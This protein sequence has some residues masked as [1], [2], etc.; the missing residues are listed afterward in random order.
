MA[1]PLERLKSQLLTSGVQQDNFALYQVINQLIGFLQDEVII[2]SNAISGGGGGGGIGLVNATYLT[3]NKEAGLPNSLQEIA[4]SGIQ[5]NDASGRRIISA[6]IPFGLD[7]GEDGQDGV[8][9]PPGRIGIVGSQGLIGPPGMPGEDGEDGPIGPPGID[10]KIGVNGARGIDGLTGFPGIDGEDGN[11]GDPGITGPQGFTGQQGAIGAPGIP[12]IDGFEGEQGDMGIPGPRGIQ[13]LTG[14]NSGV[15]F[16]FDPTDASDIAGYKKALLNPSTNAES[17]IVQVCAG[18][19]NNLLASFVTEPGIPGVYAIPPGA[20]F[21]HIHGSVTTVGGFARY[22]VELYYCN[23][24]GTGETLVGSSYSDPTT[25]TNIDEVNWD[26]YSLTNVPILST[27]R[28]VWKL[29]V[30]RVSGPVNV[31][32]TTYFEGLVHPS[33]V[34]STIAGIS[35]G[36]PG[37]IGPPGVSVTGP[38]YIEPEEPEYPINWYPPTGRI[39]SIKLV[40]AAA[41]AA[42][43]F[44]TEGTIDWFVGGGAT[45]IPVQQAIPNYKVLGEGMHLWF[46]WV[47]QGTL[48]TQGSAVPTA[49]T[50]QGDTTGTALAALA[51]RQGI[52]RTDGGI[53]YG[54]M[55]GAFARKTTRVLRLYISTFSAVNTITARLSDGSA[56]DVTTTFDTGAATGLNRM[57]TITYNSIEDFAHLAVSCLVSTNRGSNPNVMYVGATLAPS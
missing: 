19:G 27:Q 13:G 40:V 23:A 47:Y 6:A 53:N 57:I 3:K 29:Y 50:T 30:A 16:W 11:D 20:G 5:F 51:T 10:G 4:G 46:Q 24:D 7:S 36:V 43:N 26:L 49:T 38:P 18:V 48:F 39:G 44:T 15:K 32:V 17:T 28:L 14:G 12:G 33:Y 21:R 31:S 1:N 41:P 22:F 56:A 34:E 45:L 54:V 55:F 37:P 9:G 35:P 2:T 8:P 25:D 52:F 42:V